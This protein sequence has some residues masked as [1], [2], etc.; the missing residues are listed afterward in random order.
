MS[1]R[2]IREIRSNCPMRACSVS[3]SIPTTQRKRRD[4][5]RPPLL[6]QPDDGPENL[7]AA[8]EH[9]RHDRDHFSKMLLTCMVTLSS[10][11]DV[12]P[13]FVVLVMKI[14]HC[15]YSMTG[16]GW[17]IGLL[18]SEPPTFLQS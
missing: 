11:T 4:V 10:V 1:I 6:L 7:I 17:N 12:T 8:R 14:T 13:V 18:P 16:G 9:L 3:K 5:A 15:S 2:L